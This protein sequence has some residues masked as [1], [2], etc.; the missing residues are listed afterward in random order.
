[1]CYVRRCELYLIGKKGYSR[2]LR[3]RMTRSDLCFEIVTSG[4]CEGKIHN[5]TQR[6]PLEGSGSSLA[7][8]MRGTCIKAAEVQMKRGWAQKKFRSGMMGLAPSLNN[9]TAEDREGV[10]SYPGQ[11]VNSDPLAGT[12]TRGV[13]AR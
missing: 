6:D 4:N 12:Q 10:K 13:R 8:A 5:Q 11:G 7:E 1:M 3:W 9:W 2:F